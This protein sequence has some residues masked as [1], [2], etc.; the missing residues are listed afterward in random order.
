MSVSMA[1]MRWLAGTAE[2]MSL[3]ELY[4]GQYGRPKTRSGDD[5]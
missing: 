5:A 3:G 1:W 2:K 4:T